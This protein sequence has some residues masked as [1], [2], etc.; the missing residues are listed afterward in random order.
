MALT[1]S[2]PWTPQEYMVDGLEAAIRNRLRERLLERI[3][4]DL[5]EAITA[6]MQDLKIAVEEYRSAAHL[7]QVVEVILNDRRGAK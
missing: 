4:P 2:I 3:K 5:D 6:A 1:S 7:G